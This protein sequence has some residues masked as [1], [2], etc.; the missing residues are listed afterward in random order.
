MRAA[1][2][3]GFLP[4][5]AG[6]WFILSGYN[7]DG[8]GTL[9][10]SGKRYK[11]ID[12]QAGDDFTN[13]GASANVNEEVFVYNGTPPADWTNGTVIQEATTSIAYNA[14]S[15]VV[16]SAMNA[17]VFASGS[18][19]TV[20]G[21]DGF[22]IF[23]FGVA[24]PPPAQMVGDTG[25]L[26]PLC[27]ADFGTL[28]E[29][30]ATIQ[31][32]QTVRILQNVAAFTNL[33][34][35][36]E[37]PGAGVIELQVGGGGLNAKYRI[38]LAS[39]TSGALVV[40][41]SYIVEAYVAGDDFVNVGGSNATD[42]TFIA[43]GTTPTTWTNNSS[44]IRQNAEQPY[45]GQ[46]SV[47]V[48][49]EES[50]MLDYDASASRVQTALE[51]LSTVGAGNVSVSKEAAGK[52]LIAFRGTL[53]DTDMGTVTC[54]GGSLK[55]VP[56]LQG[57]LDL[58]TAAIDLLLSGEDTISVTLEI[59]GTPP[60]G[61]V[62]KLYRV[63]T[64]LLDS[65]IDPSSTSPDTRVTPEPAQTPAT[66]AEMLALTD[67]G[68]RS[69][70]PLRIGQALMTVASL[71]ATGNI[72][73]TAASARTQFI[74]PGGAN[75]L[76]TLPV[77]AASPSGGEVAAGHQIVIKNVG[78]GGYVLTIQNSGA[79]TQAVAANED[80]AILV[81]TAAPDSW[82]VTQQPGNQS[83]CIT[84]R[85]VDLK[86][87]GTTD[88]LTVPAGLAFILTQAIV[89]TTSITAP[90]S[91]P[92]VRVRE[93]GANTIMAY[94]FTVQAS[95]AGQVEHCQVTGTAN[96]CAAGNIVQF[97]VFTATLSGTQLADVTVIGFL[98]PA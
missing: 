21:A 98:T 46:F 82:E 74:H 80:T 70:S 5:V 19:V 96:V 48:L 56:T 75:R 62:Q 97:Q 71:T 32:V 14:S 42:A 37:T 59:E 1:I 85:N 18:G 64:T 57:V 11:I 93:S 95:A 45:D 40:G 36:G 89:R 43:T 24:S 65:I 22:F 78:T 44:L 23:T 33:D 55:I 66:E 47:V 63:S 3:R 58:R 94:D 87:T 35:V 25:G 17:T 86:T 90:D 2:G 30:T 72:T 15:A 81:A 16:Q 8:T 51:S 9:M 91:G 84:R 61:T 53:A 88:L 60:G 20:T 52:Y 31:E 83:F 26:A 29:G 41:A 92:E 73:L 28:V 76:V 12:Y 49:G 54:D 39:R 67:P 6:S 34:I 77:I 13:A 4:P 50:P 79:V 27:V 7:L 10:T 68:I 38:S 69:M